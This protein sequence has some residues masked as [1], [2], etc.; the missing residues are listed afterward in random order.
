MM[1]IITTSMSISLSAISLR[2]LPINTSII[3]AITNQGSL[4]SI[5]IESS[6]P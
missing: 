4:E 1:I 3:A 5:F 2:S 6:K